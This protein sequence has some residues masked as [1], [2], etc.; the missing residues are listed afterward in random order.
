MPLTVF[1]AAGS[2]S[3]YTGV[4]TARFLPSSF[5][6]GTPLCFWNPE[7]PVAGLDTHSTGLLLGSVNEN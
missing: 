5:L 3:S 4:A 2:L 7:V 1:L 6:G